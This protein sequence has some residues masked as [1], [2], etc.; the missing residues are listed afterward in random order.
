MYGT[1]EKKHYLSVSYIR[2]K[3]LYVRLFRVISEMPGFHWQLAEATQTII[4]YKAILYQNKEVRK[5]KM[6]PVKFHE[7][8][9]IFAINNNIAVRST[10]TF[11]ISRAFLT[12]HPLIIDVPYTGSLVTC[13]L[14]YINQGRISIPFLHCMS[15]L[16]AILFVW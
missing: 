14:Q 1:N 16:Y 10:F 12:A 6:F 11:A 4:S 7:A 9:V 15:R 5:K 3:Y 8:K 13:I 2:L